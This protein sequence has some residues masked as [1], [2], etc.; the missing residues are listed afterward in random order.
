[1]KNHLYGVKG[2]SLTLG[3]FPSK[4]KTSRI[5]PIYKTGDR[6]LCDNFRPISLL[7]LLSKVL[8]KIVCIQLVNHLDRNKLLNDNQFGFQR[9]KSTEHNLLKAVNF[10]GESINS[11][12]FCI[13][14][15]FD[16]T[17]AFDVVPHDILF[18]KL[19]KLGIQGTAHK[20]FTS[21]LKNRR[22]VVDINGKISIAKKINISVLQG[23][24]LG[25]ILFLCIINDLFNSTDLLTLMFADDTCC[26]D[27]D[28]NLDNLITKV[29]TERNKIAVWFKANKM[30][31]NTSK[32]KYIIFHAKNIKI[33]SDNL[34]VYYN[35]NDPGMVPNPD[36]I[37]PLERYH[38][39]HKNK[40]CRQ[41]K[42]LGIH[43]D[44]YLSLDYHVD[45]ICNKINRS[46]LFP[47][48]LH[49]HQRMNAN[50]NSTK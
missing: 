29:N 41:Y 6:E 24:I 34:N 44:E 2:L 49:V 4:L 17:K 1:M 43:L 16:H 11:G 35:A 32:T 21:Y 40:N 12:K 33:N 50:G 14:V 31:T 45:N 36:L 22:Q 28:E 26:L 9:G 15:C 48:R 8:E 25:P 10:I 23:S 42:L 46:L 37:T 20:C 38:N 13:S 7:S 27:S 19:T 47:T 3:I 5:V 30:A 18:K 39:N